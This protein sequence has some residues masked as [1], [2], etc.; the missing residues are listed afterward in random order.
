MD[1]YS[2]LLKELLEQLE[3]KNL[4]D[5]VLRR[6]LRRI[7]NNKATHIDGQE[8]AIRLGENTAD[9][10]VS[11]LLDG[12]EIPGY[13]E[14]EGT[15]MPLLKKDH[16]L[17]NDMAVEIQQ[18]LYEKANLGLNPIRPALEEDRAEDL[19]NAISDA[20]D[21]EQA[22]KLVDN[23]LVDLIQH[24]D[25]K[26]IEENVR[27]EY[28]SGLRPKIKREQSGGACKW[29]RSLAGTYDYPDVPEDVYRRHQNCRCLVTYDPGD[30][31]RRNVHS[32]KR[33]LN[34]EHERM[35]REL[36]E[37]AKKQSID[38]KAQSIYSAFMKER[39]N[40]ERIISTIHFNHEGLGKITPHDMYRFLQDQGYKVLP[41][42]EGS[43]AGDEFAKGG[44]YRV[45]L[46]GDAYFQYH[47]K[48]KSNQQVHHKSPYWRISNGKG[49]KK[50]YDM[51]GQP[52][53]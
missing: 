6:V 31:R 23:S 46:G 25:D 37:L 35:E 40:P 11:N 4:R 12:S 45:L 32:K 36:E 2:D 34:E 20:G 18:S 10:I 1:D 53:S 48:Y 21:I 28:N 44:G 52:I 50:R 51:D 22:K 42:N 27:K 30:G 9:V 39:D 17:I 3:T 33:M 29:C 38:E 7:A 26:F 14:L 5:R 24:F 16:Q 41:L 19:I 15:I 8:F 43:F 13:Y 49:G 47:P